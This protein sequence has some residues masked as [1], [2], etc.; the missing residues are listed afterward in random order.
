MIIPIG[1]HLPTDNT[2]VCTKVSSTIVFDDL[3]CLELG[4]HNDLK[5]VGQIVYTNASMST[6]ALYDLGFLSLE[7]FVS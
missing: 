4:R 3:L 6:K 1:S 7:G 2:Q 5:E